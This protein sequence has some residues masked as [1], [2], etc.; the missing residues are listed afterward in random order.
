MSKFIY[1]EGDLRLVRRQNAVSPDARA[2]RVAYDESLAID[3]RRAR[4][5]SMRD[6]GDAET[7]RLLRTTSS[8][9]RCSRMPSASD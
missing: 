6:E 7:R 1:E 2:A 9:W 3:E 8:N 4:L 5:R